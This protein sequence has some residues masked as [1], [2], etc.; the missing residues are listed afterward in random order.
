[1]V[2]ISGAQIHRNRL[3]RMRRVKSPAMK[4]LYAQGEVIRKDAAESISANWTPSPNHIVSDPGSP[5]NADTG[6]LHKSIDVRVS[7][8]RKSV[9][10]GAMAAYAAALEFGTS[11]IAARPF[12][13]PA[14]L[15]NRSRVVYG[16]AQ[17]VRDVVRVYKSDSAFSAAGSRYTGGA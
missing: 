13:R 10:V 3:A 12:M 11:R 14:L 16:V 8:T 5:P 9:T 17:A 4:A 6:N 7:A 2:K 1:M 15:R